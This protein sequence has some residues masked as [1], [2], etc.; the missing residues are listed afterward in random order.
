MLKKKN[1]QK[2]R[3]NQCVMIQMKGKIKMA[4]FFQEKIYRSY[5]W[6]LF[7]KKKIEASA[8]LLV[9]FNCLK[10]IIKEDTRQNFFWKK[11]ITHY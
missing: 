5:V 9:T 3:N 10:N 7:L 8:L 1:P 11:K 6:M 4:H 2:R